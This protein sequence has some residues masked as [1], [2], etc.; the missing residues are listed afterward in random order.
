MTASFDPRILDS[1]L[2]V[3]Y[4]ASLVIVAAVTFFGG[5][6]MKKLHA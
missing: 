3:I 2:A 4:P 5:F 1:H 6:S